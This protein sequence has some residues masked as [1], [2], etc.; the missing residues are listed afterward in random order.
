MKKIMYGICIL[1]LIATSLVHSMEK[2]WTRKEADKRALVL[3]C[4]ITLDKERQKKGKKQSLLLEKM[5]EQDPNTIP[6]LDLFYLTLS[7]KSDIDLTNLSDNIMSGEASKK[8][9]R[10]FYYG[11]MEEHLNYKYTRYFYNYGM[12]EVIYS[13]CDA[14]L[15]KYDLD[16]E[17]RMKEITLIQIALYNTCENKE[18][19]IAQLKEYKEQSKKK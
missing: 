18:T 10:D 2:M 14:V 11:V 7:P 6:I 8:K 15:K 16:V 17:R 3:S 1:S 4:L 19:I 12:P 5:L 13:E 9:Y